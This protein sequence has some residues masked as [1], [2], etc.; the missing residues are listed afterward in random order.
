MKVSFEDIGQVLAT[1]QAGEGVAQGDVVKMSANGTVV[2]CAAGERFCGVAV[3]PTRG[4]C[5]A[6]QVKGFVTVPCT[7]SKVVPGWVAL[8]ADG[9]KG[10]KSA[11]EGDEGAELLVVQVENGS[12]VMC[13]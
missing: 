1:C 11:G 7:D 4:G 12:A 13:L 5:A 3:S 10:V 6:V 8:T 9:D 2:G